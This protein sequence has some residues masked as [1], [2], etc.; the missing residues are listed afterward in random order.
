MKTTTGIPVHNLENVATLLNVL[1][2]DEYVLYT[3]TKNAHWNV[4]GSNFYELHIF[5]KNQYEALDIMV[6]DIA[7]RIRSIGH[8]ALGSL[9]N[10]ISVTHMGEE[11]HDF[12]KSKQIIQTL[13][14]DHETIIRIIRNDIIPISEKYKDLGT[15]GFVNCLLEKHEKMAW[16]LRAYLS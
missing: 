15:A 14:N 2:A 9:K 7:E 13:A 11:N 5:F 3:K 1:L 10:F 8:F 6:D 16:M 12:D 4:K